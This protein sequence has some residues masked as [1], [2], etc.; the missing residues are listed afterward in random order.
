MRAATFKCPKCGQT[1]S[2]TYGPNST[3][4]PGPAPANWVVS[5]LTCPNPKCGHVLGTIAAPAS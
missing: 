2:R 1:I 4:V 3:A 5:V